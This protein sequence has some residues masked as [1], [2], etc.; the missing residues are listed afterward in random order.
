ML[1]AEHYQSSLLPGAINLPYEFIDEA[2]SLLPGKDD[3]ISFPK[4]K[5]SE[6]EVLR[7]SDRG[8]HLARIDEGLSHYEWWALDAFLTEM[9]R[10]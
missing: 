9:P 7:F 3:N 2:E 5:L 8:G 6:L 4:H 10:S 1:S